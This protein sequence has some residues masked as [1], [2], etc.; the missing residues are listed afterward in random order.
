MV[1]SITLAKEW[2]GDSVDTLLL[3]S[4]IELIIFA[5]LTV[6]LPLVYAYEARGWWKFP[7]G[8]PNGAGRFLM[9]MFIAMAFATTV[10]A[11]TLIFKLSPWVILLRVVAY[12][13]LVAILISLITVV[14]RIQE[15]DYK[16]GRDKRNEDAVS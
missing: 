2:D 12:A 16:E 11:L 4:R 13:V 15:R 8:R 1:L 10:S 9:S 5:A 3:I 6:L 7:D 14:I